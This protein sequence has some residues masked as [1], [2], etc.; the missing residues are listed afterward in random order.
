MVEL[1]I[2]VITQGC[3]WTKNKQL[4]ES[5]SLICRSFFS[6]AHILLHE[7]NKHIIDSLHFEKDDD[8][9]LVQSKGQTHYAPIPE[10]DLPANI[11]GVLEISFRFLIFK[12]HNHINSHFKSN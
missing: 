4:I 8:R 3:R 12:N 11:E 9:C 2:E 7:E 1:P 5:T 6:A 10:V